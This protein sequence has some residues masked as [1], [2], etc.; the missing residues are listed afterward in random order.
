MSALSP[1]SGS[2]LNFIERNGTNLNIWS[3]CVLHKFLENL[4]MKNIV[5]SA[6]SSCYPDVQLK[7]S[8]LMEVRHVAKLKR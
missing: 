8:S 5:A 6:I 1:N 2:L 7:S 4:V 3:T